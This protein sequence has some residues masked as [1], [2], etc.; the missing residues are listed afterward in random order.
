MAKAA[1][2]KTEEVNE[3]MERLDH[4]LKAEVESLRKT[5]KGVNKNITEEVKWNAPSFSYKDYI[6]TFNLRSTE[7]VHLIFHNPRIAEIKSYLLEGDYKDRRMTYFTDMKDVK[8]K[9]DELEKV[10]KELI[11][12]MYE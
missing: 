10:I 3:Y 12:L 4:P 1:I 2:N 6:C 5:I 11:K 8:S 9:S 7:H